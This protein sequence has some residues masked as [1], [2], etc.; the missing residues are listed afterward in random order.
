MAIRRRKK[1]IKEEPE[2]PKKRR[3][4][5][6]TAP[7][8]ADAALDSSI[9]SVDREA[10]DDVEKKVFDMCEE[11]G[12][13]MPLEFLATIMSGRDPR[14]NSNIYTHLKLIQDH[15]QDDAPPS[16]S[17]YWED[18]VYMIENEYEEAPVTLQESQ[19]AAKQIAEYVHSKKRNVQV[20]GELT[21]QKVQPLTSKE[22]RLFQKKFDSRY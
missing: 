14:R 6:A 17:H 1:T 16:H 3:R 11:T 5:K 19:A 15:Y 21:V 18:L 12:T 7:A 8:S 10:M 4:R 9:Q 13:P 2:K 20:S 22:V